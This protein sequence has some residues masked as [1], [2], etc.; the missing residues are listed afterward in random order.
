MAVPAALMKMAVPTVVSQLITLIYNIAD[1]WFIGRTKN[2]YMV[3]ASSLVLTVFLVATALSNLFG[4]SGVIWTQLVAD[5]INVIVSYLIF[6]R[7]QRAVTKV[8]NGGET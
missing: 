8:D 2:P 1:T 5:I 4:M 3:G 6:W 7:V